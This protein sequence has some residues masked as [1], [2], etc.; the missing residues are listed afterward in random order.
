[1]TF[2]APAIATLTLLVASGTVLAQRPALP[3]AV[4]GADEALYIKAALPLDEPRHLCVD[5][6]GHGA[7][8][9]PDRALGVH[10]CKDGM[11]NLDQ[12]FRWHGESAL[13]TMP[14]YSRCLAA[15]SASSGAEI[16]LG[17]CEPAPLS[18]WRHEEARLRLSSQPELCL[19]IG[20]E[21]SELTAGG[22]RFETR[23][24]SRTLSLETCSDDALH[25]QLFTIV[26]PLDLSE[27]L[28]PPK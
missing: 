9:D 21:A 18:E 15:S 8:A 4:D 11:W 28:L 3:T 7:A 27:P 14:Q 10:T 16:R 24:V 26:E 12:R 17:D 6:P 2:N 22:R 23:Y 13:L 1:M 5:V 19:T 25:R 20:A